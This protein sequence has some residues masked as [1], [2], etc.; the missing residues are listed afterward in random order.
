MLVR[1]NT[2]LRTEPSTSGPSTPL[3]ASAPAS[4]YHGSINSIWL[5]VF[6]LLTII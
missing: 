6:L 4:F 3:P 2:I 1:T 5:P